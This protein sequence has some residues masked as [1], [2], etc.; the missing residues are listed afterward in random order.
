MRKLPQDWCSVSLV[1]LALNQP[2][3]T[4]IGPFGSD[5]LAGDYQAS[6]VPVVFVRDISESGFR[7]ISDV[8]VT[9]AKARA[10]AAHSVRGGDLLLTKMGLPPCIAAIYPNE[11]PDG[12]I[13]ADIVRVRPDV[14]IVNPKWLACV[15]NHESTR[16]QVRGITGGVTR[17]K[18]TLAD[19][20]SLK[21]RL[22]PLAEQRRIA[23]ILDTLDSQVTRLEN[24]AAT[25][26]MV[27]RGVLAD[28][29]EVR[30]GDEISLGQVADIGSGATPL[31]TRADY[32]EFG[33][34]P[35]V[36]TA[37]VSFSAVTSS[38]QRITAAAVRDTNLRVYP[39]GT[40][41]VAMYG[42]GVTRGRSAILGIPAAVNQACAAI[43]CNPKHLR[44]EYLFE[45]LKYKYYE[46]R[47][48]G[49]GSNQTN[50]NAAVLSSMTLL[51]PSIE[52]Q[53]RLLK[54][55]HELD[56]KSK[57]ES[58]ILAKSRLVKQGLAEDLLMGR[59]RISEA[60]AVLEG[61]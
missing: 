42:E 5:L 38:S 22:P 15:I 3:S 44:S 6:G 55:T 41:L 21:F 14:N 24:I 1:D 25:S 8:Y 23:E 4:T 19:V 45:Y 33:S 26:E 59:V 35:W 28:L 51:V 53:V 43:V 12:I 61:L 29:L 47:T 34:I 48:L 32:W 17:P 39:A 60:E 9:P 52:D 57:L 58:A 46:L 10:L 16:R 27:R 11:M 36:R 2:G 40:V 50:L 18:V 30:T 7:W 56:V 54:V 37:E 20:R 49:H 13:T 31:R